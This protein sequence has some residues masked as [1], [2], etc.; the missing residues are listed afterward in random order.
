MI[1][2]HGFL[3]AVERDLLAG[4]TQF[5]TGLRVLAALREVL[6]NPSS[7]VDDVTTLISAEPLIVTRLLRL[8]NCVTFNPAGTEVVSVK[9]AIQRI[10]F[11]MVRTAAAAVAIAQ[12]RMLTGDR[13]GAELADRAWLRSVQLS[14]LARLLAGTR[15][16]KLADE[17]GLCGLVSELGTFYLIQRASRYPSYSDPSQ[18]D[19]LQDLLVRH[20]A[21]TTA[22]LGDALGLPAAIV[23][24]LRAW[25][26]GGLGPEAARPLLEC[27]QSAVQA[28]PQVFGDLSITYP[29]EPSP[30][31][32]GLSVEDSAELVHQARQALQELL[33]VLDAG[34]R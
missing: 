7:S 14:A 17:A 3:A 4:D 6:D 21:E 32:P 19:V 1:T 11:D 25:N 16:R 12:M 22:R 26:E 8:A 5:P 27:M 15:Q 23:A 13:C 18:L 31:L 10:G 28:L 30:V 33:A 20:A 9:Y 34:G 24:V 29:N 2:H